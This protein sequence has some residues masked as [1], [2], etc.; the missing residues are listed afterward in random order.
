[1]RISGYHSTAWFL[2]LTDTVY[3][4]DLAI[5]HWINGLAGRWHSLDFLMVAVTR[6]SPIIFAFVLLACWARWR[7]AWQHGAALAGI[8][9]LLALG[10]GQLGNLVFPRS[11]PFVVTASTVLIPHAP[12]PSFP[13]DHAILAFAVTVV[14]ATV[15][16]TFGAWLA[17]FG[18]LVLVSR[19]FVGAHYPTDV[20]GGAAL[21]AL[22]AWITLRVA[23]VATVA[24]WIDAVFAM[25]RRLKLAAP[26]P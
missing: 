24:G 19:V 13:S 18:V 20:I 16:R 17:A 2:S 10:L 3:S 23:R 25:L 5:F 6:Y 11:R 9:A 22:G 8:A 14:L 7:A 15:N 12:D 21:G 4:T 26:L 1:M